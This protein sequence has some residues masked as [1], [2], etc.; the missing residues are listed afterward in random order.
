MLYTRVP[1]L[2]FP[3]NPNLAS[4]NVEQTD[5]EKKTQWPEFTLEELSYKDLSPAM[6]NGRGVKA[7]ECLMWNEI[8]P[9]LAQTA[10]EL[11]SHQKHL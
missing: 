5:Q 2:F 9:K 8:L 4:N 11:T 1:V 7:R 10:G 3:S 6:Q